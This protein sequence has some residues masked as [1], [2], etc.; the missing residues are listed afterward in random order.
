MPGHAGRFDASWDALGP[1]IWS[2]YLYGLR[3]PQQLPASWASSLSGLG[4]LT[5]DDC[6]LV[7]TLP[8]EWGQAGAFPQLLQIWMANNPQLMGGS[9]SPLALQPWCHHPV[10]ADLAKCSWIPHFLTRCASALHRA[11][12]STS[13]AA[14]ALMQRLQQHHFRFSLRVFHAC[15]GQQGQSCIQVLLGLPCRVRCKPLACI[16]ATAAQARCLTGAR[17]GG[18]P[19]SSS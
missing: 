6:G 8:L 4:Y 10:H 12:T 1:F 11:A 7:G 2:F 19:D 14:L 18:C 15:P 3:L 13:S 5:M 9:S 16:D 17:R